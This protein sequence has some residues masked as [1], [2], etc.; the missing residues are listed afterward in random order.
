MSRI[1]KIQKDIKY[2]ALIGGIKFLL[3]LVQ[4][5]PSKWT[6][7]FCARLGVLS[8]YLL[9]NEKL[10]TIKNLTIAYGKEKDK[11]E[12][13]KMAKEVFYN[14]GRGAAELATKLKINDK[15]KYFSNVEVIGI[16]HVKKAFERGKGIINIVPHLGCWEAAPKAFT[17]LGF[18][19]GAVAKPLSNER[20]DKWLIKNREYSGFKIFPRGITYKTILMFLRENNGLA[21]L[22]DVDSSI[23]SVFVD[24]YGKSAHTPIGAAM[25]ALDSDATVL[26]SS[27]VRTEG[28]KFKLICSKP[29]ELIRTGDRKQELQLNTA[30]FHKAVED[31]IK[32]YPTQWTWMHERWKTTPEMVETKEREKKE[33]RLK[34]KE[35]RLRA[36]K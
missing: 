5:T 8:F 26:T 15:S 22:I 10:K 3:F 33:L 18:S 32:T 16:E 25:L 13:Y 35:E 30:L 20:L 17:L 4:I 1:K 14:L 29:F 36:A 28:N 11:D 23:K 21:M 6:S 24:F 2:S 7:I 34:R 9:K 31:Q 27:Y 19:G 12:I